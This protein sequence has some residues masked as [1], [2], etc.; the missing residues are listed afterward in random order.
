M[1]GWGAMGLV[2]GSVPQLP[3]KENMPLK[4]NNQAQTRELAGRTVLL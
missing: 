4:T 2:L 1:Q 3:N